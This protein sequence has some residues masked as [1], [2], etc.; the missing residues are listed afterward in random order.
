MHTVPRRWIVR[1]HAVPSVVLCAIVFACFTSFPASG[2]TVDLEYGYGLTANATA[3]NVGPVT[4]TGPSATG[5]GA[6]VSLAVPPSPS[7]PAANGQVIESV[8]YGS[9]QSLTA[10]AAQPG[11][12]LF[13]AN[14]QG[15]GS[16]VFNDAAVAGGQLQFAWIIS[17][18]I[19]AFNQALGT[20][21]S[22]AIATVAADFIASVNGTLTTLNLDQ[23]Y[24]VNTLGC[25]PPLPGRTNLPPG[26]L[27]SEQI[28]LTGTLNVVPGSTVVFAGTLNSLSQA[29]GVTVPTVCG[30]ANCTVDLGASANTSF[31]ALLTV[32]PVSPGAFFNSLS[33]TS[34]LAPV[35][36]PS[37][38]VLLM[39]GMMG[40]LLIPS[41][42]SMRL[43][44]ARRLSRYFGIDPV[45]SLNLR[46]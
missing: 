4:Q 15:S 17:G 20:T 26:Q 45:L 21:S 24:C 46:G 23:A 44:A 8:Q 31:S 11:T 3:Q 41:V 18:T 9:L 22:Q 25:G 1:C 33:G 2:Q 39:T 38:I 14:G 30:T 6:N 16:N 28:T 13:A 27:N 43:Q 29:Q 42:H 40:I 7:Q 37:S 36:E 19:G 5:I 32:T 12:V 10:A 34:Y 35:P